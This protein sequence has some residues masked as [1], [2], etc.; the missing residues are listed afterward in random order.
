MLTPR[1]RQIIIWLAGLISTDG[2]IQWTS[3]EHKTVT[4]MITSVEADWRKLIQE[5]LKEVK[6]NSSISGIRVY[7][8]N[9]PFILRLLKEARCK[10]FFNPRKWKRVEESHKRY[11]TLRRFT[12]FLS[13]E[14]QIIPKYS[15]EP[16]SEYLKLLPG[17]TYG[18]IWW[19][20]KR[21]AR[22]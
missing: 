21:L 7:L 11:Q 18:S 8:H 19:R 3:G 17:R 14:D 20:R 1:E 9:P 10:P 6:I 5:R 13:E 16:I 4:F 2:S 12:R 15:S 22:E